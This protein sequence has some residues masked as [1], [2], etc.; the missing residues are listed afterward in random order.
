[1][2]SYPKTEDLGRQQQTQFSHRVPS[3]L[4]QQGSYLTAQQTKYEAKLQTHWLFFPLSAIPCN[5]TQIE[6]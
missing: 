2:Q 6:L 1:M 4:L 5:D 3:W